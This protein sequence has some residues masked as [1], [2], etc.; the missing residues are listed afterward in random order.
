MRELL[1][2]DS[3]DFRFEVGVTDVASRLELHD[4]ARIVQSLSTHFTVIRV[5]AQLDQLIE[6]LM[7]LGVYDLLKSNPRMMRRLL[8]YNPEPLT[9]DF[10]L[11]L[12]QA[13]FSPDQSN[14]REDEE[15]VWMYWVNFLELIDSKSKLYLVMQ[16][17]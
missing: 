11:D 3:F 5:K 10:I 13:R 1:D 15:Q 9:T 17:A 2:S 12:F 14:R 6:G 4:R 16:H 8:T 7:A